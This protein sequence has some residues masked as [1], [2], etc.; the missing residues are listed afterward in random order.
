MVLAAGPRIGDRQQHVGAVLVGFSPAGAAGALHLR[1]LHGGL[2]LQA[3]EVAA[4]Q[5]DDVDHAEHGVLPVDGAARTGDVFDAVDQIQIQRKFRSHRAAVVDRIIDAIAIDRNQR[6]RAKVP[7]NREAAGTEGQV[8]A[9]VGRVRAGQAGQCLGQRAPAMRLDFGAR[10]DTYRGGHFALALLILGCR[11]DLDVQQLLQAHAGQV[12]AGGHTQ[13]HCGAGKKQQAG[14]GA[15]RQ[16]AAAAAA[17]GEVV[18]AW[19]STRTRGARLLSGYRALVLRTGNRPAAD[20]SGFRQADQCALGD[21][22]WDM[23]GKTLFSVGLSPKRDRSAPTA[24]PLRGDRGPRPV[25]LRRRRPTAAQ[26]L[27]AQLPKI[28]SLRTGS[29]APQS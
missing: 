16:S 21:G 20:F 23:R 11:H 24:G 13:R 6:A 5:G 22:D 18:C 7:G 19:V 1:A 8:L 25:I 12:I 3:V 4:M 17:Q 15:A 29:T 10:D 27:D 14:Q 26:F 2:E 9:V 28:P